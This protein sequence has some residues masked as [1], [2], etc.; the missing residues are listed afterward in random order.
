MEEESNKDLLVKM[1]ISKLIVFADKFAGIEVHLPVNGRYVKLNYASDQFIEILRKLQQKDVEDVYV[2]YDDCEKIVA[3]AQ[4]AMS[5]KTFY[6]PKTTEEQR[7]ESVNAAMGVV[8]SVINQMGVNKETVQLLKTINTRAMSLLAESPTIF[9]FVKRFKKNC[10]EEFL[11][12]ILTNYIMSL[13]IDKFPWKSDQVKEKGA[14]A[15]ML[16]DI[17]LTKDDF[18]IIRLWHQ[19]EGALPDHIKKHPATIAEG[20]KKNRNLVPLETITIIEQHHELPNGTGFP[21]GIQGH[22]FNQLSAIFITCQQFAEMLHEANYD[23]EK[24]FDIIS[25]LRVK[26]D[27]CKPFEKSIEALTGVIT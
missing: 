16:C 3:H 12:S 22:R 27:N 23:Y 2:H 17:S 13:V 24:R 26:F 9:A 8:K 4:T 11:L 25:H 7:V 5:S 10:S 1:P 18:R 6:D 20:L 21:Y 19:G 14:L 15:S